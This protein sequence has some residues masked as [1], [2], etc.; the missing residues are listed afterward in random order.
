MLLADVLA[1]FLFLGSLRAV[2]LQCLITANGPLT[3]AAGERQAMKSGQLVEGYDADV[4]ALSSSPLDGNI[5]ILG[6]PDKVILVIK[7]GDIFKDRVGQEIS[8]FLN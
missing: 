7:G 3:L 8:S 4:I 1:L 5:D 2:L 6:N